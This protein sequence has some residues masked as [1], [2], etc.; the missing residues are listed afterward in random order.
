MN[1]FLSLLP[2]AFIIGLVGCKVFEPVISVCDSTNTQ[3]AIVHDGPE[4]YFIGRRMY[5]VDY[6]ALPLTESKIGLD[7]IIIMSTPLGDIFPAKPYMS[8]QVTNFIQSL[9]C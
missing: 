8:L 4:S 6:N 9:F 1:R 5:K 3:R 2:T 7:L